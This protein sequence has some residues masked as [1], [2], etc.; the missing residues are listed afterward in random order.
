MI[1]ASFS[2]LVLTLGLT[3]AGVAAA[4]EAVQIPKPDIAKGQAIAQSVCAACHAV[5]GNSIGNTFPKLAGQHE[6]YLATELHDF[7]VAPGATAAQRPSAVMA[8][9]AAALSDDD[10]R[11]VSAYF[12]SQTYKPSAAKN[13]NSIELGRSIYRGGI[14]ER[15]VPAC[16]GCHSPNG[17]GIPVE[18]PRIAGQFAEYSE[19]QLAAFRSGARKN[20][21]M[22]VV[23]GRMSDDEIRA[24]ADYVAGLR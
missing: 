8:A 14:D 19:A 20:A 12:A 1:R 7:K 21:A 22:S 13:K 2:I 11:N 10:I 5:D 4:A 24:V 3:L 9:F 6:A 23:A 18:Y 16:A 17:A 15:G